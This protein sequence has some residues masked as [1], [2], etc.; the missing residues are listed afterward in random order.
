MHLREVELVFHESFS[1]HN[2]NMQYHI[3]FKLNRIPLRRQHQALLNGFAPN[4]LLFPKP[5]DVVKKQP[6]VTGELKDWIYNRLIINNDEQLQAVA[7][8][9]QLNAGHAPFVVFGP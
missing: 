5:R 4:R 9:I 1:G 8:I 2:D 6:G 7:S 3:R